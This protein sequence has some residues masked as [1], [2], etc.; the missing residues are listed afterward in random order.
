MRFGRFYRQGYRAGL[1]LEPLNGGRYHAQG[2]GD[3]MALVNQG[4]YPAALPTLRIRGYVTARE[5]A[6]GRYT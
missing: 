3:D 1:L 5:L 4:T 2:Y 6:E